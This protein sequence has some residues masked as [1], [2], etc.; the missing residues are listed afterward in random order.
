MKSWE[1][2]GV[3]TGRESRATIKSK[4]R[5]P[6][7]LLSHA[8]S[9]YFS[10]TTNFHELTFHE[11]NSFLLFLAL[12]SPADP[13]LWPPLSSRFFYFPRKLIHVPTRRDLLPFLF[14]F[15][16]RQTFADMPFHIFRYLSS[17]SHRAIEQKFLPQ[18]DS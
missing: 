7:F 16:P 6:T 17:S 5:P 11:A 10:R 12:V 13:L 3:H 4:R 2:G 9:R 8:I 18:L 15:V 1:R 14:L